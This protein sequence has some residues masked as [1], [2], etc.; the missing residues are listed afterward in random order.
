M[1]EIWG[2]K[3]PETLEEILVPDVSAVLSVDLQNDYMKPGGTHAK[4]G[5]DISRMLELLPHCARFIND[6]RD[7][8]VL[9]IHIRIVTQPNGRSTSP[10]WLRS[11]TKMS[12]VTEYGLEGTWG[13]EFCQEVSPIAGEPIVTKYRSSAFVN[14]NLDS[15]LRGSEIQT[16]VVIGMQTQ[17]CVEATFRDAAYHDY[18]NVLVEDCVGAY[19]Q[20]LHEA[21]LKIQRA[22]HDVAT[23]EE[24]VALWK[25]HRD[26]ESAPP[27]PI[28]S[29]R[30]L[31]LARSGS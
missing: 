28:E 26:L 31:D 16:V 11:M 12:N 4:A 8:G 9:V 25:K 1:R 3:V 24:I 10:S 13:A 27:K 18:Y 23:S 6:A 21:S 19:D 30:D 7:A 5:N 2:K 22:R 14:T 17:G 20:E 29:P 15:I